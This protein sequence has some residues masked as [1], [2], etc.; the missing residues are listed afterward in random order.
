MRVLSIDPASF[1]EI[2]YTSAA[3]SGGIEGCRLPLL[4]GTV[5]WLPE[6]LSALLVASDLQGVAPSADHGGALGLLGEVLAETLRE[7]E[8]GELIPPRTQIGVLLAGDLFAAPAGDKRGATGD[9]RPVWAA[10][11]RE[12]RWVA[13]VAG[14]HD[15]FGSDRGHPGVRRGAHLL[16]G[17]VVELDGLRVGGVGGIIGNTAKPGRRNEEDF[18]SLVSRVVE[19]NPDVLVLHEGPDDPAAGARGNAAVRELVSTAKNEILV[20]CGHSP[21]KQPLATINDQAQVLN[22][23]ERAVLLALRES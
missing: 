12:A 22:V 8:E 1:C 13:G 9:V 6:G 11:A 3:S 15:L 18:L 7:L 19:Q 16:D 23:H 21:W 10:F 20:A 14:N 2:P 17:Q 5:D 4:K